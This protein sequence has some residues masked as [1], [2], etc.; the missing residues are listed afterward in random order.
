MTRDERDGRI[1]VAIL[2]ATG[3]VGQR[4]VSLLAGHPSLRLAE[5][6]ASERSQGKTYL[7]ATRWILPGDV[8]EEARGLVVTSVEE[9]LESRLVLSALDAKVADTVEP[10]QASRGKLVVSNTKSFRMQADV[11][12]LIPEVNADHLALLDRQEWAAAGR[13]DRH[14]PQLRRGRPRDGARAAPPRVRA[15]GGLRHDAPGALGS[16]LPGRPLARRD[17]KRHSVHRRRGGEDRDRAGEDPRDAGRRPGR[18]GGLPDLRLRQPGPR[19][20]RAHRV[21]LREALAEGLARGDP[22][23]ARGLRGRA[24]EA[25]PPVGSRRARSSSATSATARSRFATWKPGTGWS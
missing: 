15:G 12:L 13:R 1:P 2:G 4:M 20:R 16:G 6:A 11:P 21:G 14:E 25:R 22:G 3:A 8:P 17:G 9:E 19:A 18:P 23:G 24:A 5:V 7:E 10:L